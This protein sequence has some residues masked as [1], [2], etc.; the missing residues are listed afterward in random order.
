MITFLEAVSDDMLHVPPAATLPMHT[1][2]A[3]RSYLNYADRNF[4]CQHVDLYYY[5]N[6]D[7]VARPTI[8]LS[9]TL[10]HLYDY[11]LSQ[12]ESPP[13]LEYLILINYEA[14][15]VERGYT[16]HCTLLPD[17]LKQTMYD[18]WGDG[19]RLRRRWINKYL[20]QDHA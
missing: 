5:D 2:T 20:E 3:L 9:E 18:S 13:T 12:D 8:S 17:S 1:E 11:I 4:L 15:L 6:R 16:Q 19:I 7:T 14:Q 10:C